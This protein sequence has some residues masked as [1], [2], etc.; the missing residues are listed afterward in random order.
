MTSTKRKIYIALII[1]CFSATGGVLYFGLKS[2]S[3][4]PAP[5][6]TIAVP[7][8]SSSPVTTPVSNPIVTSSDGFYAVPQVFPQDTKFDWKLFD[9]DAY[10]N[11]KPIPD[12]VLDPSTVGTTNPF[13]K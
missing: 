3:L 10:K 4:P 2:P 6:V 11:L 13:G 5:P 9:S 1:V 8:A 12:L 7:G